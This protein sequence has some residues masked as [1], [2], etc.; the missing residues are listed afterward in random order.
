M[1]TILLHFLGIGSPEKAAP[2]AQENTEE[3]L[4]APSST[5]A[6][7]ETDE[8]KTK[9]KPSKRGG[10]DAVVGPK[11]EANKAGVYIFD[12]SLKINFSFLPKINQYALRYKCLFDVKIF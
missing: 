11:S 9:P 3:T 10:T 5:P 4:E 7:K 8:N 2:T 6:K 1:Y 12:F